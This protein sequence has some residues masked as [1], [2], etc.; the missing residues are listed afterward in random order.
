MNTIK[1]MTAVLVAMGC[2]SLSAFGQ[3][4]GSQTI[5]SSGS[6]EWFGAITN[7][8]SCSAT[9]AIVDCTRQKDVLL[10]VKAQLSGAG[11]TANTVTVQQSLDRSNWTSLTAF[12]WTPA[13]ATYVVTATNLTINA[14]PYIRVSSIANHTS[15]TGYITNYTV[16]A[17]VK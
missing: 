4:G 9:N 14:V 17:F 6:G 12:T 3:I 1:Y 16:K 10:V 15:N 5:V 8:T 11:T 2:L 7:N 13:G